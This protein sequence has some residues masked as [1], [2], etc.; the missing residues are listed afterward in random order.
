MTNKPK[1]PNPLGMISGI[2]GALG[3]AVGDI[4]REVKQDL[5]EM[6]PPDKKGGGAPV[7]EHLA[8]A[9]RSASGGLAYIDVGG[10]DSIGRDEHGPVF[11]APT[12]TG[13][14][15]P[16]MMADDAT[17]VRVDALFVA[18]HADDVTRY[19]KTLADE[20]QNPL[21]LG[22]IAVEAS[23]AAAVAAL[24]KAMGESTRIFGAV[25]FGPRHLLESLEELDDK[26]T[27]LLNDNPKILAVGPLGLDE[28][29]A[30]YALPQQVEQMAVQMQ[31]AADFDLP[32]VL[33]HRRSLPSMQAVLEGIQGAPS[34]I[35][36][37]PLETEDDVSF[38]RKLG[39][40]VL[41]R[42]EITHE[43]NRSARE[44]LRRILP[45][46]LLL[47]CGSSLVSTATRVGHAGG[48]EG[49]ADT[50]KTYAAM[51]DKPVKDV[52]RTLNQNAKGVYVK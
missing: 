13:L 17:R 11:K 2:A 14:A 3:S 35:W 34:L 16:W 43:A 23:D 37:D 1:T 39:A 44:N 18:T 36:A 26:L 51:L 10:D 15:N 24:V 52:L 45:D 49:L 9:V 50:L 48:P 21:T 12:P 33:S 20:K 28:P 29:Y 38:L 47:A 8:N 6:T 22:V 30:P 19:A 41:V 31:V 40:Y 27:V 32:I 42:P 25:G 46:R 5:R 7:N 4:V